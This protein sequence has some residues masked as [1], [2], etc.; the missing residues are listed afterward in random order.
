MN[1]R[2][3]KVYKNEIP[4]MKKRETLVQDKNIR[5]F[6]KSEITKIKKKVNKKIKIL[7]KKSDHIAGAESLYSNTSTECK[8]RTH[9]FIWITK[10]FR[11]PKIAFQFYLQRT[12][13]HLNCYICKCWEK[14]W[15]SFDNWCK[16]NKHV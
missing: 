10:C 14:P 15:S 4:L 16:G 3:N 8:H 11:H 13:W 9:I 7:Q 2:W 1:R 6:L 12:K 5:R